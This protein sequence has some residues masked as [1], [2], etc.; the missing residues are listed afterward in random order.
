LTEPL[1]LDPRP[2][3]HRVHVRIIPSGLKAFSTGGQRSSRVSSLAGANGLVCLPAF[4]EGGPKALEKG[5]IAKVI[6]IGELQT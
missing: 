1:P 2:E 4:V 6:M 3:F 5:E